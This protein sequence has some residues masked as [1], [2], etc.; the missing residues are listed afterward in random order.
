MYLAMNRFRVKNGQEDAFETVW[1]NRDSQLEKVPGFKSFHLLKGPRNDDGTIL[2][3]SH[4]I[5]ADQA[6]FIA[7]TK[8]EHFRIAHKNAGDN[9][10]LYDGPP[11]FEGFEAVSGA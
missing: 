10:P 7:W 1:R 3:A 5:W 6:A 9:K 11:S 2:Y 8:S 4:T